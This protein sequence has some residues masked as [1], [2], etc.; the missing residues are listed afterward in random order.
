MTDLLAVCP[1]CGEVH[2][3]NAALKAALT[4][5]ARREGAL[6]AKLE[7]HEKAG[8]LMDEIG[9]V[10]DH[11][12]EVCR[13]DGRGKKPKLDTKRIVVIRAR[14]RDDWSVDDLKR[15]IDGWAT[16]D[17]QMGRDRKTKGATRLSMVERLLADSGSVEAGLALADQLAS[18]DTPSKPASRAA[19]PDR[20][21]DPGSAV[22]RVL[23]A[24]EARNLKIV[25]R[26]GGWEA[27]CP[28]HDDRT[29]SLGVD[30][31]ADSVLVRCRRGCAIEEIT[32]ALGLEMGALFDTWVDECDRPMPR[33]L[34]RTNGKMPDKP[35]EDPLPSAEDLAAWHRAL[36]ENAAA[37]KWLFARRRWSRPTLERFQVGL[38]G[39][40]LIFPVRGADGR[41]LTIARYKPQPKDGESKMLGLTGRRRRPFPA[42]EVIDGDPLWL[43]EGEP[44]VLSAF[45]MGLGAVAIPGVE[46]AKGDRL[47][48]LPRSLAGHTVVVCLDCDDPGRECAAR[49]AAALTGGGVD[50]VI[51]DLALGR[52]DGYDVGD[53]LVEHGPV[54]GADIMRDLF[55]SATGPQQLGIGAAA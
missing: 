39:G 34:H 33:A 21:V 8:P 14:L 15:A 18:G 37:L 23:V 47:A 11:W 48:A 17:W 6:K 16:D 13:T 22:R 46:W 41:L 40:R 45:E 35:Q 5:S 26:A 51:V 53:V 12:L 24:L 27:Q 31:A 38:N 7:K 32:H 20:P 25:N 36:L 49:V 44:D 50:T 54:G 55:A 9:Q 29:P 1:T 4:A 42:P 3:E 10:F 52:S 43:V 30:P 19:F 28:A 2:Q